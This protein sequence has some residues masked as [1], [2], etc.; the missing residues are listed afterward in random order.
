MMTVKRP[1]EASWHILSE[2]FPASYAYLCVKLG[3]RMSKAEALQI[4]AR[5][6][7]YWPGDE[8]SLAIWA[9]GELGM[10]EA[11]DQIGPML[12]AHEKRMAKAFAD[13]L[14]Q[15]RT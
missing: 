10:W 6:E 3:R 13:R 8:Q 14:R 1:S 4:V 9:I 11:L 5:C 15:S 7:E 12:D 2:R